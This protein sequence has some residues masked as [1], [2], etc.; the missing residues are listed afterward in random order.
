MGGEENLEAGA[1]KRKTP[2]RREPREALG[3]ADRSAERPQTKAP[4]SW[5]RRDAEH[6]C[7]KVG[8]TLQSF[9]E[10]KEI[11]VCMGCEGL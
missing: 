2:R 4:T 5:N 6:Y 3:D 10:E 8:M 1:T 9:D 11:I 7:G